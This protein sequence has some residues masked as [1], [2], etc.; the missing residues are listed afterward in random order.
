MHA[1]IIALVEA[2]GCPGLPA[3]EADL[4]VVLRVE[5]LRI[6]REVRTAKEHARRAK[7]DLE[8]HLGSCRCGDPEDPDSVT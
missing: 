5:Y 2:Y 7:V 8:C 1:R 4:E 3:L 6:A